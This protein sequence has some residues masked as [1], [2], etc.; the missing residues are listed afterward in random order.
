MMMLHA[1]EQA[2]PAKNENLVSLLIVLLLDLVFKYRLKIRGPKVHIQC[3]SPLLVI[4]A[5]VE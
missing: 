4:T 2:L 5:K 1:K 3:K